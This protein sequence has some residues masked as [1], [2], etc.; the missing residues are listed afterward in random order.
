LYKEKFYIRL[1]ITQ[2]K[3]IDMNTI[4]IPINIINIISENNQDEIT[5]NIIDLTMTICK[6]MLN[7]SR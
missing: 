5:V 1:D 4:I 7:F 6:Q 2:I 3:I